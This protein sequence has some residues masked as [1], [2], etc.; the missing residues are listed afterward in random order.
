MYNRARDDCLLWN[1][2]LV[3][4]QYPFIKKNNHYLHRS[5]MAAVFK[6]KY[7]WHV[8]GKKTTTDKALL[9]LGTILAIYNDY[10]VISE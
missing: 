8:H 9:W 4:Y 1:I 7:H 2:R 3:F 10:K 5:N 6:V